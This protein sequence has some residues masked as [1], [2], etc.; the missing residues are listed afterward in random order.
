MGISPFQCAV[1]E[2]RSK[3]VEYF[4]KEIK[5]DITSYDQVTIT[6]YKLYVYVVYL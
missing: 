2:G 4:V 6:L 5:V 1:K 3:I